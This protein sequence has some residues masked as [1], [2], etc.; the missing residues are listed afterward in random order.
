MKKKSFIKI[1]IGILILVLLVNILVIVLVEPWVRIKAEE[2]LNEKFRDNKFKIYKVHISIIT[3]ILELKMVKISTKQ[4]MG[5]NQDLIGEIGS[6]KFRRIHLLK[7]IFAKKFHIREIIFSNFSLKGKIPFPR[8]KMSP[9]ISPVNIM[10]DDI[11]FNNADID[12]VN[13]INPQSFSAKKVVFKIHGIEADKNDTL[14]TGIIKDLFFKADELSYVSSDSMYT[15]I[16]EGIIYSGSEKTLVA[17]SFSVH[18]NYTDY[19]FVSHYKY[20]KDRIEAMLNNISIKNFNASDYFRS[21]NIVSS[22]IEIGNIKLK[23]FRDKRKEFQH[24]YKPELQDIIYDYR[25]TIHIDSAE[26]LKGNITYRE[27]AEK[28]TE[29]GTISFTEMKAKIYNITNDTVYRTE[30]GYMEFK[31]EAMFMGKSKMTLMYKAKIFNSLNT[32]SLDGTLSAIEAKELNPILENNVFVYVASGKIDKMDFRYTANKTKA[33]G[34]LTI[35][36]NGLVLTAKNK[37]TDDTTAIKERFISF[38][39]NRKV[40]DSNPVSD[41]EV[42]EG[43]IDYERDPEKFLFSYWVK[44]ILS[45]IKSSLVKSPDKKKNH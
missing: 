11:F 30:N 40:I 13:T 25:G 26:F 17:D 5:R 32:S 43:I 27:H 22:F 45:G 21:G 10:I 9:I 23:V 39:I 36:Y 38:I 29:A 16:A 42:R 37:R 1:V 28:A 2:A 20:Q 24:V 8:T 31:C 34:R 7:A 35:L 14:S 12:L 15:F 3:S 18:P 44:S 19:N 33:T 6:V 4:N 41:E